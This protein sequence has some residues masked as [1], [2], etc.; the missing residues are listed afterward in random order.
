M[1]EPIAQAVD[2]IVDVLKQTDVAEVLSDFGRRSS[3][4]PGNFRHERTGKED[5]VVHFYETFLAAYDPKMRGVRGVYYT[6]EP[7]VSYIV[8]SI[9][10]LLKTRFDRPNG[11]AD[12]NTLILDPAVGT[13]TFLSFVI[14]HIHRNFTG[15]ATVWNDYV[16]RHLI[17]RVFGFEL[18]PAPYAV[19]HLT[20]GML[21]QAGEREAGTP[22]A[23]ADREA[24]VAWGVRAPSLRGYQFGGDRPLG[25]YLANTLEEA[26]AGERGAPPSL[27]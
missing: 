18:L 8:R 23:T 9:D 14:K 27:P 5:P 7:V 20:L 24:R 21:L 3:H 10:H 1:P 19:A 13:G 26:A 25:I 22:H 16:A 12:E 17:G 6:P 4:L 2:D 11:L 15:Q